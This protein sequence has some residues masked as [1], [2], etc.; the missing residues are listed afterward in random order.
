MAHKG[1]ACK[2]RKSSPT[3]KIRERGR[4]QLRAS[5]VSIFYTES[6]LRPGAAIF[7][8]ASFRAITCL[9]PFSLNCS[10]LSLS[11]SFAE[12][13]WSVFEFVDLLCRE[14]EDSP[15]SPVTFWFLL[16]TRDRR[17]DLEDDAEN[18]AACVPLRCPIRVKRTN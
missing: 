3:E 16:L 15:A 18:E 9:H 1:R 8:A 13:C 12:L 4:V 11:P 17:D 6:Q 5:D 2:K 10:P 7:R 14:R